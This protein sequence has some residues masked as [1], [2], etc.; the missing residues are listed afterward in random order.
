MRAKWAPHQ[1]TLILGGFT[2][3]RRLLARQIQRQGREMSLEDLPMASLSAQPEQEDA[4]RRRGS[5]TAV[6][7]CQ[8]AGR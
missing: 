5:E 4:D 3:V 7:G 6:G 1:V 8:Q 2:V